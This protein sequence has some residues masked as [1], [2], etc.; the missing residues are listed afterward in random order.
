MKRFATL[1]LLTCSLAAAQET[2]K[3][4]WTGNS[5]LPSAVVAPS[6]SGIQGSGQVAAGGGTACVLTG[7]TTGLVS[8]VTSGDQVVV[9]ALDTSAN[10]VTLTIADTLGGGQTWTSDALC[11][12]V[13]S[14]NTC[15]SGV[16]RTWHMIASTSGADTITVTTNGSG[17]TTCA[18][19]EFRWS[20]GGL[21]SPT[22]ASGTTQAFSSTPSITTT[23][24]LTA[25]G[26]L[27]VADF[28]AAG[29]NFTAA[30]SGFTCLGG[31]C[32]QT[33]IEWKALA[34][35]SG[36]GAT[37]TGTATSSGG[38]TFFGDVITYKHP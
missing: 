7:G 14:P 16:H 9:S 18:A 35:G 4:T 17:S 15:A 38:V 23:G 31:N 34:S 37:Q 3:G 28:L 13:S 20:A 2:V 24:N 36:S 30:G 29:S 6:W 19:A 25:N 32:T 12:S 22:D 10:T 8:N 26:E 1:L 21:S 27:V 33:M 5:A 11:N